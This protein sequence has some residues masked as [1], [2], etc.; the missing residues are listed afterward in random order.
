MEDQSLL[1]KLDGAVYRIRVV[2][3]E[4]NETLDRIKLL[5]CEANELRQLIAMAESKAEEILRAS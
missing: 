2:E 5:E 3:K 1:Q 4:R